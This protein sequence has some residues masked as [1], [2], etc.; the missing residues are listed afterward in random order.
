METRK[1]VLKSIGYI[2][3][4]FGFIIISFGPLMTNSLQVYTIYGLVGFTIAMFGA[5]ILR[6]SN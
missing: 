2:I 6:K 3:L 5:I 4:V 1:I